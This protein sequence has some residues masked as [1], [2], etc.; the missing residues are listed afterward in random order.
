MTDIFPQSRELKEIIE[1]YDWTLIDVSNPPEGRAYNWRELDKKQPTEQFEIGHQYMFVPIPEQGHTFSDA[2]VNTE[3][4]GPSLRIEDP[5]DERFLSLDISP[6]NIGVVALFSRLIFA[7]ECGFV[8]CPK[9]Y[10]LPNPDFVAVSYDELVDTFRKYF[11][12]TP[13]EAFI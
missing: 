11:T 7:K 8:T 3:G 10:D 6:K 5:N 12:I 1:K 2:Y 13:P 9:T 4:L